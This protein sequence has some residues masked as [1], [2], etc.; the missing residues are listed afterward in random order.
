MVIL[1]TTL[2]HFLFSH[3]Y[4]ILLSK[5]SGDGILLS[6]SSGDNS[7]HSEES[8]DSEDSVDSVEYDR[9]GKYAEKQL[10]E[11]KE[12]IKLAH[13]SQK[14]PAALEELN[15]KYPHFKDK[16][17]ELQAA[18]DADYAKEKALREAEKAKA[19]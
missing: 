15:K 2:V 5:S 4:G 14:D 12:D 11:L 16:P 7:D 3:N 6:K 9:N 19:E 8:V 17:E 1:F 10:Q 18:L 13:R